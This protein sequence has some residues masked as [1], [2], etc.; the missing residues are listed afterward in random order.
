M[1]LGSPADEAYGR[2]YFA[3]LR[4]VAKHIKEK[5]AWYRALAYIKP[6]GMNLF[7]D[8]NRLPKNCTP[9]CPICNTEEWAVKG[10]Y[11]P[12]KLREFYQQQMKV[13]A[14]AF[15][16]KDMSYMLI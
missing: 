9:D 1:D 15:P 7:T 6:S 12:A 14:E 8:E 5:N 4:E 13:L 11:T 2:Y 16:D 3:L 10:D